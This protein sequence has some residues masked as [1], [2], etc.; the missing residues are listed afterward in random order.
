MEGGGQHLMNWFKG[1]FGYVGYLSKTTIISATH[2]NIT[3]PY[4]HDTHFKFHA[5]G[6]QE[7]R[8][9]ETETQVFSTDYCFAVETQR[10]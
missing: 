9:L 3:V 2:I 6:P 8:G 10:D 7:K 4:I 5:S 1:W